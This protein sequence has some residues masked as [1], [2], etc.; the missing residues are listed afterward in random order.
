MPTTEARDTI[1]ITKDAIYRVWE[2]NLTLG[3]I[4]NTQPKLESFHYYISSTLTSLSIDLDK[5]SKTAEIWNVLNRNI[6]ILNSDTSLSTTQKYKLDIPPLV[7]LLD[8]E[9]LDFC[10]QRNIL[11]DA[12][13][14][15]KL[16]YETFQNIKGIKIT[17]QSDYEIDNLKMV[18]FDVKIRDE[19]DNILRKEDK[20]Y[21]N[22]RKLISTDS[23]MNFVLTTQVV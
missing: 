9:T 8:K 4:S 7:S 19:I 15:F 21:E 22:I 10:N 2:K 12:T 17:L 1:G 20:F 6:T 13:I 23:M 3:D 11:S 14:Y 18:R 16:I 5:I